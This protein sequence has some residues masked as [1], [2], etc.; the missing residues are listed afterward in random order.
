MY[1]PL[2]LIVLVIVIWILY[3]YIYGYIDYSR[4]W[5]E[6]E[7]KAA[8]RIAELD[9][10]QAQGARNRAAF[11]EAGH[12]VVARFGLPVGKIEIADD[13]SGKTEIGPAD[14]L[15]LIDQV[16]VRIA[17]VVA[18]DFFGFFRSEAG[19]H[20]QGK[21]VELVDGLTEAE[22]L[23]LRNAAYERAREIIKSQKPEVERL[24]ELLIEKR[25]AGPV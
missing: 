10:L 5:D 17:G 23:K 13:G 6:E 19:Y 9:A 22:S 16:A 4:R 3:P 12:V 25:N 24:A 8:A 7:R 1:I 2:G 14:H 21:I 15:P 11:H 18:Q 20:D